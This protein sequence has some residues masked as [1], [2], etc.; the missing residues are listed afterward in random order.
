VF[1]CLI[2]KPG[3]GSGAT[4]LSDVVATVATGMHAAKEMMPAGRNSEEEMR[5]R[6]TSLLMAAKDVVVL[7]NIEHALASSAL[8]AVLTTPLWQDRVLSKN[9]IITLPVRTTWI[10]TANNIAI[11]GDIGRRS[12]RVRI[13]PKQDRPWTRDTFKHADLL[14]WTREHRGELLHALLTLARAWFAA[15]QP[16]VK[17]PKVGGFE[18]WVSIIGGILAYAGVEG[19]LGNLEELYSMVDEDAQQWRVFIATWHE[20]L[21]E[22]PYTVAEFTGFASTNPVLMEALP[23]VIDWD[24]EKFD[25]SKKRLGKALKKRIDRHFGEYRLEQGQ[26]NTDAKVARWCVKKYGVYGV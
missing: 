11:R 9:E 25:S 20:H 15:G 3:P 10:A 8:S 4:L 18:E 2:D 21:G 16:K 6:I 7:D 26:R 24:P 13:D 22:Q 17:T 5:K 1:P 19:F 23:D 14:A 12:Y